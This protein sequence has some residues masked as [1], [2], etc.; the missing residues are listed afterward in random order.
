MIEFQKSK[1]LDPTGTVDRE[2]WDILKAEYDKSVALNSPPA[3]I[4]LFPRSPLNFKLRQ[5]DAGIVVDAVQYMLSELE[6]LYYFPSVERSGVYDESTA[7]IIRDFQG[8]NGIEVT[9]E[10]DRET[11]DALAIQHNLLDKYNE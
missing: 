9:G 1:D 5:G 3:R 6:R 11:W 4:D 2:T 8:R 10:V 7:A